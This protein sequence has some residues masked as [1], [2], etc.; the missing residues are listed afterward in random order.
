MRRLLRGP[1]RLFQLSFVHLSYLYVIYINLHVLTSQSERSRCGKHDFDLFCI[2]VILAG[3]Q[4]I[5]FLFLVNVL[6]LMNGPSFCLIFGR[7][8]FVLFLKGYLTPPFYHPPTKGYHLHPT[9]TLPYF[10]HFELV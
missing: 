3:N 5:F 4:L 7:Q 1:S 9:L 8:F 6:P 2:G 10:H